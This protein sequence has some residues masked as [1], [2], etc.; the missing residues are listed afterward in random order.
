MI[1]EGDGLSGLESEAVPPGREFS[2]ARVLGLGVIAMFVLI[3]VTLP[4][5]VLRGLVLDRFEVTELQ[6]SLF[7]SLNMIAAVL[8]APIAGGLSDRWGRRKPI[9]LVALLVDAVCWVGLTL[10]LSFSGFLAIRFCEGIAHIFALSLLLAL[11]SDHAGP[12]RRGRIM[13]AAGAGLTLGVALGAPLGGVLGKNDP[14]I[15]LYVGAGLSLFAA[16]W[17]LLLLFEGPLSSKRASFREITAAIRGNRWLLLPLV[18]AFADRFTVGFFTTTFSLYLK[19]IHDLDPP[20]IGFL[21]ALFLLPFGLL[22]YGFGRLS[23]KVSRARLVCLGSFFYGLGT[24][25]LGWWSVDG[26]P[27]LMVTLGVLSAVMFVPSLILTVDLTDSKLKATALGA[28]N[29]AGSLGFV[30]GPLTGGFV[31]QT[32]AATAGWHAGYQF[33]FVVAGLAEIACV[34]IAFP[35]FARLSREGKTV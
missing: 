15:P 17:V 23:E 22:S 10:P 19:R 13:G 18:F 5:T 25:T 11:A 21:L 24:L 26:L 20:R 28:F 9:I 8:A 3:P 14:F 4:V 32:V 12:E 31:S 16:F 27:I 33:A 34:L 2:G 7:M 6:T 1:R 29:A 30:L 35:F